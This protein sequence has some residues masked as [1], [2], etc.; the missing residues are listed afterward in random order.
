VSVHIAAAMRGSLCMAVPTAVRAE[1]LDLGA[2]KADC[3]RPV[4][5]MCG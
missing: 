4:M 5:P 3:E 2:P 1:L